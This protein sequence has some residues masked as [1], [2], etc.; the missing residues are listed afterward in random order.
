MKTKMKIAIL[1]EILVTNGCI[2]K[3]QGSTSI[4]ASNT[5]IFGRA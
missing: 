2:D 1:I 4:S 3:L 5:V